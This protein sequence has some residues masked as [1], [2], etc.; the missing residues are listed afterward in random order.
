MK[1]VNLLI[2]DEP[3]NHL[4]IGAIQVLT[5]ALEDFLG[6]LVFVSHDEHF[7]NCLATKILE[8]TPNS[9]QLYHGNW[10][11][12]QWKKG[13]SKHEKYGKI[14]KPVKQVTKYHTPS[15]TRNKNYQRFQRDLLDKLDFL[16]E[17]E[18]E[19]QSRLSDPKVYKNGLLVKEI[20]TLL[21]ENASSQKIVIEDWENI[22]TKNKEEF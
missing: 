11:Y 1:P 16:Q 5:K 3:T 7:I 21:R 2:L 20:K 13:N 19:L 17:Q 8:I 12:F 10:D 4:D 9:S 14:E 15:K 22:E 18:T 6:T